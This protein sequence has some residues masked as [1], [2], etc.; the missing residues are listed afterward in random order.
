VIDCVGGKDGKERRKVL[1]TVQCDID[2]RFPAP[3]LSADDDCA[4]ELMLGA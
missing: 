4:S 2:E 3:S 1:N